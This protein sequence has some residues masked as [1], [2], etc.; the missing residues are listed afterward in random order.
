MR[1]RRI[2]NVLA[3]ILSALIVGLTMSAPDFSN[4]VQAASTAGN[5]QQ[6][7]GSTTGKELASGV[8]Y[9]PKGTTVTFTNNNLNNYGGSGLKIADGATVYI[10]IPESSTLAA[11][12]KAASGQTGA[13]AGIYVP[14]GASLVFLG[15]GS[16]RAQGGKG[17][18]G[19]NGTGGGASA[20]YSSSNQVT[21]GAG[22][23]GGYGGGGAGAGIGTNGGN[24][25]AGGRGAST[26]TNDAKDS[27]TTFNGYS[28]SKGSAGTTAASMGKVY[29]SGNVSIDAKG[30]AAGS[31]S[32]TGGSNGSY[33]SGS[34]TDGSWIVRY[35]S[36]GAGGGGGGYG[37]SG[38]S[39]GTGGDGA[40][41]GGGGAGAA[42]FWCVTYLGGNGGNGGYPGGK[43]GTAGVSGTGTSP[44][45][46]CSG[47]VET[48]P[49][50][51]TAASTSS[52]STSSYGYAYN[53]GSNVS[54]R[55]QYAHGGTG[56]AGGAA[57]S[58]AKAGSI[59][60]SGA[61][62]ATYNVT[63]AGAVSDSVQAYTFGSTSTISVPDYQ[64]NDNEGYFIGWQVEN[65]GVA[66][67]NVAASSTSLC[68]GDTSF[69]Q[70]GDVITVGETTS[71][72]ITLKPVIQSLDGR[73]AVSEVLTIDAGEF[74]KE[75]E[76]Y[77]YTVQVKV[78]GALSDIGKIILREKASAQEDQNK[79]TSGE[80][81]YALSSGTGS[82]TG[83]YTLTIPKDA[84]EES[85]APEFEIFVKNEDTG[86]HVLAATD[87]DDRITTLLYETLKIETRLD[88]SPSDEPGMVTLS[89]NDLPRLQKDA[90]G[91][92]SS[93]RLKASDP[94]KEDMASYTVLVGGKDTGYKAEFGKTSVIDYC[95]VRVTVEGNVVPERVVLK[96][97]SEEG[98][99]S[100]SLQNRRENQWSLIRQRSAASYTVYVD[101]LETE[102]TNAAFDGTSTDLQCGL[103]QSTIQ[104]CLDGV[105]QDG[106][107]NNCSMGADVFLHTGTGNYQFTTVTTSVNPVEERE[108]FADGEG[109][110]TYPLGD[111]IRLDYYS[112]LYDGGD[113]AVTGVP[114]DSRI[115]RKGAQ[116][117]LAQPG[118]MT[119]PGKNFAG[120]KVGDR[121]YQPGDTITIQDT[122]TP[123]A[124]WEC[125]S[126]TINY[127]MNDRDE[128]DSTAD[129]VNAKDNPISYTVDK[130][131]TIQNPTR[132]GF[133]FIGWTYDGCESP[134]TD[135][136]LQ[137]GMTGD[138]TL[139]ANWS[140][141][142]YTIE[143]DPVS[144]DFG[145][146]IEGYVNTPQQQIVTITNLGNQDITLQTP[147][148]DR[149]A[150]TAYTIGMLSRTHLAPGQKAT[151][152]VAPQSGLLEGEHDE[153]IVVK[154]DHQT[155]AVTNVSFLVGV[156]TTAPSGYI[157]LDTDQFKILNTDLTFDSP[158]LYATEKNVVIHA[159]DDE[160]GVGSILY[161]VSDRELSESELDALSDE[162]WN[163]YTT[164]FTFTEN[165]RYA[166]Y[167]K[168]SDREEPAN[169]TYLS[170]KAFEIDTMPPV[171][172]GI[173]DG[174][175][176]GDTTFTVSDANLD[177]V[178][179]DGV[180]VL[181][182]SDGNYKLA[183]KEGIT[184]TVV[185]KDKCG[186]E[187][188]VIVT[189]N[190]TLYSVS[191]DAN[192]GEGTM[193]I[194]KVYEGKTI[195]LP[196]A[197][198]IAP[199]GKEFAGWKNKNGDEWAVGSDYTVT[200]DT[201]LYA[202]WKNTAYRITYDLGG[203]A[204]DG[205]APDSYT[206]ED[207]V[208]IPAP[209]KRGYDFAGWSMDQDDTVYPSMTI[210]AGSRGDH[211]LTAHWTEKTETTCQVNYWLQNIDG[212][213][214]SRDDANYTKA[215]SI[216][217]AGSRGEVIQP[218][219]KQYEGF[220]APSVQSFTLEP[221]LEQE[222]NNYYTR[223]RYQLTLIKEDGIE[224]SVQDDIY[225]YGKELNTGVVVAPGYTF[226]GLCAADG[227]VVS[228]DPAYRF[229][230]PAE[231]VTYYVKAV[232]ETYTI[233][234]NLN[235]GVAVVANPDQYQ[236]NTPSFTLN[237]PTRDGFS[238]V[239]WI[240]S[241]SGT[242][243]TIPKGTTGNL[244]F[245]AVWAPISLGPVNPD[246]PEDPGYISYVVNH[247]KQNLDGSFSL[248]ES[249][250]YSAVG[251]TLQTPEVRSYVGFQSPDA[252]SLTV[253]SNGINEINY[254]YNRQAYTLTIQSGDG[255]AASLATAGGVSITEG[256][257]QSVLY[258]QPVSLQATLK[259]GYIFAGWVLSDGTRLENTEAL[260][261]MPA[262]DLTI[263][264]QAVEKKYTV[265]Y[266]LA[267]GSIE[268][269][270]PFFYTLN[271]GAFTLLNPTREGY[272][273]A[274]W[275]LDNEDGLQTTVTINPAAQLRNLNFT[276]HWIPKSTVAY[277]VRYWK[278]KADGNYTLA[279]TDDTGVGTAGELVSPTVKAYAGYI[280]P[281]AVTVR[282]EEDG[283][284]VVDYYYVRKDFSTDPNVTDVSD[285]EDIEKRIDELERLIQ[286][287]DVSDEDRKIFE[288][289]KKAL[290][291]ILDNL[292]K[293]E[294]ALDRIDTKWD[295]SSK[296]PG[297]SDVTE[298]DRSSLEELINDIDDLLDRNPNYLSEQQKKDLIDKRSQTQDKLNRLDEVKNAY[299]DIEQSMSQMPAGSDMTDDDRNRT[300][301][302]LDKI[303][304]LLPDTP[305][306]SN[307][308]TPEQ[309]KEL[310]DWK[311]KLEK[312][313]EALDKVDQRKDE[314]NDRYV[315]LDK[316]DYNADDL[317][318]IRDLMDEIR[319]LLDQDGSHLTDAQK[320]EYKDLLSDLRNKKDVLDQVGKNCDEV[321]DQYHKLLPLDY[322]N[323]TDRDAVGDLLNQVSDILDQSG[324]HLT[325]EQ[326]RELEDKKKELQKQKDA[327]DEIDKTLRDV[328]DKSAGLPAKEDI[329][330]KDRD[331]LED[332]LERIDH[333][334]E[335]EKSHLTD[336]EIEALE[337]KKAEVSDKYQALKES[338]DRYEDVQDHFDKLPDSDKVT[339]D[340]RN[341]IEDMIRQIEDLLLDPSRF[342]KEDVD[343]LQKQ[344][345]E[346]LDKLDRLD[347][348]KKA[349]D[350]ARDYIRQNPTPPGN[351]VTSDDKQKLQEIL[352]ELQERLGDY[353]NNLTDDE[354]KEWAD[355]KDKLKTVE[356]MEKR[357]EDIHKAGNNIHPSDQA[358]NNDREKI[359]ELLDQIKDML[360][361]HGGNL[362]T[363]EKDQL[364]KLGERLNRVLNQIDDNQ[365]TMDD[366]QTSSE[367]PSKTP[368]GLNIKNIVSY[369][370]APWKKG[371]TAA[372]TG[373]YHDADGADRSDSQTDGQHESI[374]DD[375]NG[376][377]VVAD[378][379]A[380]VSDDNI[381]SDGTDR[382]TDA[383]KQEKSACRYHW[384][385]LIVCIVTV[386][387]YFLIPKKYWWATTLATVC[388]LILGAIFCIF[389]SCIWDWIFMVL[390]ILALIGVQIGSH[391]ME[392]NSKSAEDEM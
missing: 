374:S 358:D 210:P 346:L 196:A 119:N 172:L 275:S 216:T 314:I 128:D 204:F 363:A 114:E 33:I 47:K 182:D 143:A 138:L 349:L 378:Q 122:V 7:T 266:N 10:Y 231:N 116:T 160:T 212:D 41:G 66:I 267:G 264:A 201:V 298:N 70:V 307:N 56:G 69:Y 257:S 191:Y 281:E 238:F 72:N 198:F 42:Y 78:D 39:I 4:E 168:L 320:Q 220:T 248:V 68:T 75:Q 329:T 249:Q 31:S 27:V 302:A 390:N 185:A 364:Q 286:D 60:T 147:V 386:I 87:D 290:S 155:E 34:V 380:S 383:Q 25:G 165:G 111:T 247:L 100:L 360:E 104:T 5:L 48:S 102:L 303:D 228:A 361:N 137:P 387:L 376:D 203:G 174:V 32:G 323:S 103:Y 265:N 274:G 242:S 241:Y 260:L 162:D 192:G 30:G 9:V 50:N 325:T 173:K 282:I 96:G 388:N 347:D 130:A 300:K 236:V 283:S 52:Q 294:K 175:Y 77:H 118:E 255:I 26:K 74:A 190:P 289:Q 29:N 288:D 235:D 353:E 181:P 45:D 245:E 139:T 377:E 322:L 3:V 171:I 109:V 391:W 250:K 234:Y 149:G 285:K 40:G 373:W 37:L 188:T 89:G 202:V 177:T 136:T 354:K 372:A 123:V 299:R 148:S 273:F 297:L 194:S 258:G 296:N 151:F 337:E 21:M 348:A 333:L 99:V 287:P 85:A 261:E 345:E 64:L 335:D 338:K 92:Y 36:G 230:M 179:I 243:V 157:Q 226:A 135:L 20:L 271:T 291:D 356:E 184:Q 199:D 82:K 44:G 308:L 146:R 332:I 382:I 129:A 369:E 124:Q 318:E 24:G 280:S 316:T 12:G 268:G 385:I 169:V 79:A 244:T 90:S 315:R 161:Y 211:T 270:N 305:G 140:A 366:S 339:S 187:T 279:D 167:A 225:P 362:T 6:L 313:L 206:I 312:N 125:I 2:K 222:V 163:V 83:V 351:Q 232:P 81:E 131:V 328:F 23:A 209:A 46:G 306:T 368:G 259:D 28:G 183:A 276:A 324:G 176:Y 18:D 95:T 233:S 357:L 86:Y 319:D 54:Q 180:A 80:A 1:Y 262:G 53:G 16:V 76:Y 355:L 229:T 389:G 61:P 256:A 213:A 381:K 263:T 154:T 11:T 150:E 330:G 121:V 144:L 159:E 295:D 370:K 215:D 115:Y 57:G 207:S 218:E 49:S 327:L 107:I 253:S 310:E 384:Y 94:S 214:A 292:D 221:T 141:Y 14:S 67:P 359:Q 156:D 108:V 112:V 58:A 269:E 110:G 208:I 193:E 342:P 166:I 105:L 341:D 350:D 272:D 91:T 237:N 22:G 43:G 19:Q 35:A 284:T 13:G 240:G 15:N 65:G 317:D 336:T 301:E 93:M 392:E 321:K 62:T 120:W 134:V 340:N 326:K 205:Q 158:I 132:E 88:E 126:Y 343:K 219:V 252:Q 344:K 189:V 17:A 277:T 379:E 127:D 38:A 195:P 246:D 106:L 227:T 178:T 186:K 365:N 170:T 152:T 84:E 51:G 145:T 371:K 197:K 142:V 375:Q 8:Y 113:T 352:N 224:A 98:A 278:Q 101:G 223:N 367:A 117:V 97:N 334:L 331:L 153:Q 63:F 73:K 200:E 59:L 304:R 71:G 133:L 309:K 293:T 251:G 239:G 217:V 55:Y 254:Q 311:Q 164:G